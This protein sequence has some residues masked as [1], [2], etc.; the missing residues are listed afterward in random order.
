MYS[1]K[2]LKA[3]DDDEMVGITKKQVMSTILIPS[4]ITL[5]YC[6]STLQFFFSLNFL[7]LPKLFFEK[8]K[9]V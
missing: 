8:Q 1:N 5:K 3:A 4:I 7:L 6:R 9:T 2:E